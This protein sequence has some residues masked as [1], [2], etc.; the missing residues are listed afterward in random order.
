MM[1]DSTNKKHPKLKETTG[2][3]FSVYRASVRLL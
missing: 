1:Q 2:G 3:E